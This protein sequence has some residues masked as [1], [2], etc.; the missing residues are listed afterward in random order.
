MPNPKKA[1]AMNPTPTPT[2]STKVRLSSHAIQRW[3]ERVNTGATL[4]EARFE[5][6]Q[7]ISRGRVRATP[8]HWTDAAPAPGLTFV[9]W[10]QR[11]SVC[12]LVRAGVVVT[13]LTR[14]LCRSTE[15]CNVGVISDISTARTARRPRLK[16]IPGWRWDGK[17]DAS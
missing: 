5:L 8:R 7:F 12:A 15:P 3:C 6:G 2:P 13:V 10:A 4:T 16:L 14:S 17:K 9:Y 1:S 11:P